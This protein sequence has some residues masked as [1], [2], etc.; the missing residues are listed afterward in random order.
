MTKVRLLVPQADG[1]L[2]GRGIR[3]V[4]RLAL[5]H[6]ILGRFVHTE[7]NEGQLQVALIIRNRAHIVEYFPKSRIQ[8]LLI[9]GLLDLQKVGHGHD[10][11]VPGKILA[12]G[13]AVVL[14]LGH[15]HIHL[16]LPDRSE[17]RPGGY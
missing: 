6:V 8:K 4:P 9:G 10:F 7:I 17:T 3:G 1:D 14:V 12:E 11:L 2:Q 16:S 15:L 13:F 5:L